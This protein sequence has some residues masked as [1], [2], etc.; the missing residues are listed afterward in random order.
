MDG[1]RRPGFT[2]AGAPASWKRGESACEPVQRNRNTDAFLG[3]FEH[4]EDSRLSISENIKQVIIHYD[5]GDAAVGQAA[6]KSHTPHILTVNV[7]PKAVGKQNPQRHQNPEKSGLLVRGLKDDH[8]QPDIWLVFSRYILNDRA[9]LKAGP[10]RRITTHLP[11]AV[12]R[13]DNPLCADRCN[14]PAKAGQEQGKNAEN[15]AEMTL[16]FVRSPDGNAP[17]RQVFGE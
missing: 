16:Q 5:L 12:L 7:K 3:S 10:G 2:P 14:N 6:H 8:A 9:L 1:P 15:Y 13:P 11:V 4:H 17:W